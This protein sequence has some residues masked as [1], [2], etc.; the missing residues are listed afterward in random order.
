MKLSVPKPALLSALS[1]ATAVTENRSPS[2][3]ATAVLLD[4]SGAAPRLYA[5]DLSSLS[6]RCTV[7]QA[8]ITKP[9]V[10]AV[11]ARDIFDRVK[12]MPVGDVVLEK[13]DDKLIIRAAVGDRRHTIRTFDVAEFPK[14]PEPVGTTRNLVVAAGAL[15]SLFARVKHAQGDEPDRPSC[16]G[17]LLSAVDGML[18]ADATNG[19]RM[20]CADL[21]ADV[22]Q[23]DGAV[24]SPKAVTLL[25]SLCEEKDAKVEIAV[26]K[27][28][29]YVALGGTELAVTLI[30][31]GY[32]PTRR[33]L[34]TAT[35]TVKTST[36][37][38]RE[39]L[40]DSV[41]SAALSAEEKGRSVVLDLAGG[42]MTVSSA[43]SNGEA[44]D[45]IDA[46][47]E[48]VANAAVFHRYLEDALGA[49]GTE[50]V[51]LGMSGPLDPLVMRP[52]GDGAP[53]LT[54]FISPVRQ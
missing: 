15:G 11:S 20:A 8:T 9:G 4:A 32:S 24:F 43:A 52:T 54:L 14:W 30:E 41:K 13:K 53:A 37:L 36:I 33:Y 38:D 50:R 44:N 45:A 29:A 2:F 17:T 5:T 39:A 10:V 42:R 35:A 1:R 34:E 22:A 7:D 3:I 47:G 46:E 12:T 49:I 48:G 6:V 23:F 31:G 18:R 26:T 21:P 16:Y 27:S 25:A 51:S 40:L 19:H 28:R